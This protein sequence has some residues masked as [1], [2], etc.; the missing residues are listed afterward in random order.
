MT[1]FLSLGIIRGLIGQIVST[2]AGMGL[3]MLI[4]S[5][6]G[7]TVWKPEPVIVGGALIGAIAFLIGVGIFRDWFKWAQGQETPLRHGPPADRP[8]W[9]R[10]FS[11]DYSHK[12]IGVQY[13]ITGILLLVFAGSLAIVFRLELAQSGLQFHTAGSVSA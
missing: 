10:Y 11:V 5:V 4:R 1:T 6:L 12:V 13:T 8:A 2:A 9:T 3:V 7:H